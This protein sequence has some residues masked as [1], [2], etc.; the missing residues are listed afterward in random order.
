MAPGSSGHFL[1][2]FL[3]PVLAVSLGGVSLLVDDAFLLLGSPISVAV[4]SAV[5]AR[6][7]TEQPETYP[8]LRL[9]PQQQLSRH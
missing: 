1:V 7:T 4:H 5:S 6:K 3:P 9:T 8:I 2:E